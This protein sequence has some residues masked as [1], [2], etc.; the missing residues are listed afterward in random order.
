VGQNLAVSLPISE[1][2]I[3][4]EI[5]CAAPEQNLDAS[6]LFTS[7]HGDH[8]AGAAALSLLAHLGRGDSLFSYSSQDNELNDVIEH[9][10][11]SSQDNE[12]NDV[13]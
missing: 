1:L 7:V 6:M 11:H 10:K 9:T 8:L 12:L 13:I 3:Y 5:C 4:A 2:S